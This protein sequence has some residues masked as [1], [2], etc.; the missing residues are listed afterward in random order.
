MITPER[1]KE[2]LAAHGE[3]RPQP[4]TD[5]KGAFPLPAAAERFYQEI[6]PADVTIEAHGNPY[7]VPRLGALWDFQADIVGT[8]SRR[9]DRELGR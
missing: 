8:A 6:G 3:V 5:W 4:P 9:A 7:F 2:L 1:A